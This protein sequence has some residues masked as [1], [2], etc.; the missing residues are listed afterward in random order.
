MVRVHRQDLEF[1]LNEKVKKF[2]KNDRIRRRVNMIKKLR[3]P[4]L[5]VLVIVALASGIGLTSKIYQQRKINNY[6][7]SY[8]QFNQMIEQGDIADALFYIS[9]VLEKMSGSNNPEINSLHNEISYIY[10]IYN[11]NHLNFVEAKEKRTYNNHLKEIENLFNLGDVE[12]SYSKATNLIDRLNEVS[13]FSFSQKYSS[14]LVDMKNN[15]IIPGIVNYKI[16]NIE[17]ERN[18]RQRK[19][20]LDNLFNF[21]DQ[22]QYAGKNDDIIRINS[23][24]EIGINLEKDALSKLNSRFDL[25]KKYASN[26][27]YINAHRISKSVIGNINRLNLVY[28]NEDASVLLSQVYQFYNSDVK[29]NYIATLKAKEKESQERQIKT[30]Q[31][32][33]GV[34]QSEQRPKITIQTQSQQN[35]S[36][37]METIVVNHQQKFSEYYS[38]M[39]EMK[40]LAENNNYNDLGSNMRT[41]E[42]QINK[43]TG[44][45]SSFVKKGFNQL[46]E[47]LYNIVINYGKS[48]LANG[49]AWDAM[50]IFGSMQVWNHNDVDLINLDGMSKLKLK[51]RDSAI[52]DFKRLIK[53]K[54]N[55]GLYH[56]NLAVAIMQDQSWNNRTSESQQALQSFRNAIKLNPNESWIYDKYSSLLYSQNNNRT[57]S[58]RNRVITQWVQRFPDDINANMRYAS[59]IRQN[60]PN[61]ALRHYKKATE[62]APDHQ[63]AHYNYISLLKEQRMYSEMLKAAR[64]YK[65]AYKIYPG[66]MNKNN[67]G[68]YHPRIFMSEALYYNQMYKEA[69]GY[70]KG[71]ENSHT[72]SGLRSIARRVKARI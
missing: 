17:S 62:I 10:N 24:H 40:V 49:D 39:N 30:V 3:T 64:V 28:V 70:V 55:E 21:I 66:S 33:R 59:N 26:N 54:P 9:Q 22:K 60:N 4:S 47:D 52:R 63:L 56:A 18:H 72:H 25:I 42:N 48:K 29:M 12:Q 23:L 13:H 41:L 38:R 6:R 50:M 1:M 58:E 65:N 5:T 51:L 2:D 31:Q 43:L 46:K 20:E 8:E 61:E 11:R 15:K 71:Y 37:T 53:L 45:S 16:K 36:N 69:W 35:Q 68:H 32:S 44:E 7:A 14:N 27:Y 57:T 34:I 67:D 19:E